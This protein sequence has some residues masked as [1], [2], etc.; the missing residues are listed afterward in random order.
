MSKADLIL[1]DLNV[2]IALAWPNHPHHG[3]AV[4]RFERSR[5]MWGTC[6]QTSKRP[7]EAIA[8]LDSLT[9]D[10]G[11]VYLAELP[12]PRS[13]PVRELFTKLL[14]AKQVTGAYLL[15]IARQSWRKVRYFRQTNESA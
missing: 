13:K 6:V 10:P 14:G 1:P 5:E 12:E 2:L 9:A 8:M 7:A 4:R 15:A 11:H 3:V